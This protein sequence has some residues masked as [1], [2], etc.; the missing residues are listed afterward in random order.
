MMNAT[1]R[2][3][4]ITPSVAMNGGRPTKTTRTALRRPEAR[5]APVRVDEQPAGDD[6]RQGDDRARRQIDAAAD[7]YDCGANGRDAIDRR[8]LQHEKGVG[9]V[10]ER[11]RSPVSWP[12]VPAE[13]GDFER[14]NRDRAHLA[15]S[16]EP[17]HDAIP[18]SACLP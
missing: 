2:A 18:R 1:P 9:R 4:P 14:E 12:Q 8:V 15:H 3:I 10:E 5:E 7:D 11:M 13:E 6:A 16:P 17:P